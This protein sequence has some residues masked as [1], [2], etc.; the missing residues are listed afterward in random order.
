MKK[1][2]LSF[3]F[4]V[5][6]LFFVK[7]ESNIF[8]NKVR[9]ETSYS[10]GFQISLGIIPHDVAAGFIIGDFFQKLSVQEPK[11]IIIL[12]PNHQEKGSF[13]VLT[14]FEGRKT[15]FGKVE[16]DKFFIEELL[17]DNLV[18]IDDNVLKNE[19]SITAILPFLNFY[20]PKTLIVPLVLSEKMTIE[21]IDLLAEKLKDYI[22]EGAVILG[23]IDFSHYLRS[24]E[25]KEKD[26]YTLTLIKNFDYKKIYQLQEDYVDSSSSLIILLLIAEK[27]NKKNFLVFYNTNLGEL[28]SNPL[29]PTTSYFSGAFY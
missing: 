10:D 2:F 14:S 25:A 11:T 9:E 16:T 8:L 6:F 1:I 23:S 7:L 21:E 22:K 29:I 19:H 4:L 24:N 28:T 5:I 27:L 26:K 18:K 12:G 17:K 15:S 3:L 20:L 13:K